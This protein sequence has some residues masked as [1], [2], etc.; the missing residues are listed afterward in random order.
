RSTMIDKIKDGQ[1][2]DEFLQKMK[3]NV[4][5]G[6]STD[7]QIRDDGS[8][9]FK[10]RLCVPGDL[11]LRKEIMREAHETGFS[12]HPGSTKMYKDLKL[13]FWW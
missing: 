3:K 11:E 4:L 6:K 12:V 8:L 2:G 10:M 9:W 5:E 1:A 13:N 7:Y